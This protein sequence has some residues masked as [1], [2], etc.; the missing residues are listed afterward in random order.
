VLPLP[1]PASEAPAKPPSTTATGVSGRTSSRLAEEPK[2]N[3]DYLLEDEPHPAH[4]RMYLALALLVVAAGLLG[5]HWHREGY[6]WAQ[7]PPAVS[8]TST[9]ST[10]SPASAASSPGATSPPAATSG[11]PHRPISKS[12]QAEA[13]QPKAQAATQP[14]PDGSTAAPVPQPTPA[15]PA[16]SQ[17]PGATGSDNPASANAEEQQPAGAATTRSTEGAST[18]PASAVKAPQPEAK[19]PDAAGTNADRLAAEGEKYLYGDGVRQNCVRA[20]RNL[21]RAAK[22]SSAKAQ[23]LLGTMY[24]TGHC[25]T[26][27]LP[28]AYR[29]FARALRQDPANKRVQQDLEVLWRQMTPDERQAALRGQ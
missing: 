4:G 1:A 21:T 15:E 19:P 26:R 14:S 20:Q 10:P 9:G 3:L 29:W 17:E 11:E 22:N 18:K 7:Q 5:W 23:G 27:D 2:R 25:V 28:T 24:A 16:Q 8:G 12:R 13:E 6:P